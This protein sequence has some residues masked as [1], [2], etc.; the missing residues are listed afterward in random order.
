[1]RALHRAT[2]V[3]QA[4]F[5]VK[6]KNTWRSVCRDAAGDRPSNVK[7]KWRFHL[8][9]VGSCPNEQGHLLGPVRIL[10]HIS[11]SPGLDRH[12]MK[13][14]V[15]IT[16]MGAVTPFGKNIPEC[17]AEMKNGQNFDL[18]SFAN[19][20]YGSKYVGA[21]PDVYFAGKIIERQLP[22][23]D[24]ISKIVSC[25]IGEILVSGGLA[26]DLHKIEG[27]GIIS[28]SGFGCA[29]SFSDFVKDMFFSPIGVDPMM[30]PFTSH[31]YPISVS[32]IQ[33]GL[34]GPIAADISSMSSSLNALIFAHNL[35]ANGFAEKMIV[36][37]FDEL[38]EIT[39]NYLDYHGH[40]NWEKN[41][42]V[43]RTMFCEGCAGVLIES[44]DSAEE[45]GQEIIGE[46]HSYA[47]SCGNGDSQRVHR[48]ENNIR[49]ILRKS[50]DQG[51]KPGVLLLNSSGVRAEDEDE[52][53][54]IANMNKEG[55]L[56]SSCVSLKDS[57]GHYMGASGLMELIFGLSRENGASTGTSILI[58]NF[59]FGGNLISF[60]CI[61]ANPS[62]LHQ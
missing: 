9:T 12:N 27:T 57:I 25:V 35:V 5:A 42:L 6:E 50:E 54:A 11:S 1:M 52:R 18:S 36:I 49:K 38:S 47:I 58:N 62:L 10:R 17:L 53:T 59:G 48:I 44:L 2:S 39:L 60:A 13:R 40:L 43:S 7:I 31:N 16:G 14:K 32:S 19:K 22:K 24:R 55:L 20:K 51:V 41:A 45:R 8:K 34:K 61:K 21:I 28:G 29:G 33:Y 23:Y 26:S 4:K 37:G 30:F 56:P 46:I 3:L 15:T